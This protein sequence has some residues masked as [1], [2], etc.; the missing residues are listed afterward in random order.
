[1]TLIGK[2]VTIYTDGGYSLSGEVVDQNKESI[3]MDVDS[4]V[5]MV[6]RSKVAF[7][8]LG[9]EKK[10]ENVDQ[11]EKIDYKEDVNSPFPQNGMTY[12]ENYASIPMGMLK[13]AVE[14]EDFSVFFGGA[15]SEKI[16]FSTGET[17]E[18]ARKKNQG[19]KE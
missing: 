8:K 6:F 12:S 11:D 15:D 4:E 7:L 1:M 19:D 5:Y 16:S 10:Q 13:G 2:V 3:F 17:S 18:E 9:A 14:E